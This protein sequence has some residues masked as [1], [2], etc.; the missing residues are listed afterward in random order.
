MLDNLL[1]GGLA[2]SLASM[3]PGIF[4]GFMSFMKALLIIVI[5]VIISRFIAKIVRK[6]LAK[7]GIDRLGEQLNEIELVQKMNTDIKISTIFSKFVYYFLLLIFIIAATDVLNMSA[8]SELIMGA[9]NMIPKILVGLVI[10]LFGT[11][12]AEGLRKV[13]QAALDSL[14]IPSA[15]IISTFLFYFI[16][17]NVVISAIAQAEINTAFL[18]Q[19]ISIVI[20]GAV[21]AFAIGYGLAS[22]SVVAN[23]LGSFYTEGRFEEGDKITIDGETGI[24]K[25]ID[26]NTVTLEVDDKEIIYPLGLVMKQKLVIHK[27]K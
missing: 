21:L 20:G 1:N 27:A 16:F 10:L 13:V 5:G 9:F 2:D 24:V 14:A 23:F 7:I 4:Q 19:N 15:K 3:L 25:D 22:R 26:R 6:L 18:E 12:L 11:L 8:I 17:I